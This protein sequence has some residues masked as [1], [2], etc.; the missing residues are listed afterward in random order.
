MHREEP[1]L[2]EWVFEVVHVV[3]PLLVKHVVSTTTKRDHTSQL[4]MM[5]MCHPDGVETTG[6][7]RPVHNL[8]LLDAFLLGDPL[9]HAR[10][11]TV[12]TLGV[13]WCCGRVSCS[14]DFKDKGC[15]TNLA[16]ALHPGA[17]L[18]AVA[19]E[20]GHDDNEGCG[21]LAAVGVEV[22]GGDF[23]AFAFDGV[24]VRDLDFY[25]WVLTKAGEKS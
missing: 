11:L 9:E 23:L 17:E 20:T 10:P 16:P 19:V 25:D 1:N 8:I 22:I 14:R 4:V 21:G 13:H 18:G 7:E 2:L 5:R 3:Q 12:G 6:T 24:C 15:D